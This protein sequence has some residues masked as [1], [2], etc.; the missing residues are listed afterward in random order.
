MSELP[1]SLGPLVARVPQPH[2]TNVLFSPHSS[3]FIIVLFSVKASVP[4]I[5][6]AFSDLQIG[7]LPPP[8]LR[9]FR[10]LQHLLITSPS[11]PTLSSVAFPLAYPW[12]NGRVRSLGAIFLL[13]L[14]YDFSF[15]Y[16]L[17]IWPFT[18]SCFT[19]KSFDWFF[20]TA[21]CSLSLTICSTF[22]ENP[23]QQRCGWLA[24]TQPSSKQLQVFIIYLD[25]VLQC[26]S[27][28][29]WVYYLPQTSYCW[30]YWLML[31]HLEPE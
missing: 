1:S 2:R 24:S 19:L 21:L 20:S 30:H 25:R 16:N 26:N 14:S 7:S 23:P 18:P 9:S 15:P 13:T 22:P 10:Q 6:D 3:L 17:Y 4:S 27:G 31:L 12:K 29:L 11:L 8:F 28:W 5:F